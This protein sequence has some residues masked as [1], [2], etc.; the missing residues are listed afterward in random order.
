MKD[1]RLRAHPSSGDHCCARSRRATTC[2][3][4]YLFSALAD[5]E[6]GAQ[7]GACKTKLVD[8]NKTRASTVHVT[9]LRYSI[10]Y[11]LF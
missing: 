10:Q 6:V 9:V 8:D 5:G 1:L 7:D 4:S 2:L 11:L 3:Q